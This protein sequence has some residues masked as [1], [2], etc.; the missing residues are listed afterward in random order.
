MP[1]QGKSFSVKNR[2]ALLSYMFRYTCNNQWCKSVSLQGQIVFAI[3]YLVHLHKW[4]RKATPLCLHYLFTSHTWCPLLVSFEL[5]FFAL[6]FK[7][8]LFPCH[9]S[10]KM[11][12]QM[13]ITVWSK[14]KL[15]SRSLIATKQ[16][17]PQTINITIFW[18]IWFSFFIT[19]KGQLDSNSKYKFYIGVHS[20]GGRTM[21]NIWKILLE[22]H[23]SFSRI[24]HTPS[25]PETCYKNSGCFLSRPK[26][27]Y[28]IANNL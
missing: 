24:F 11:P 18:F 21:A 22:F 14:Q 19:I 3:A 1:Q 20:P 23:F 15:K 8:I 17:V 26:T 9:F 4:G 13:A 16:I 25:G 12:L 2:L 7:P 28:K 27:N 10:Q 5:H 6:P